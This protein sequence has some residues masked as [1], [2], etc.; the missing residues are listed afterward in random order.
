MKPRGFREFE[1]GTRARYVG[2]KC[3]C[4]D[5]RAANTAYYHEQQAA[6]KAAALAAAGVIVSPS[7][8]VPEQR[9]ARDGTTRT[10]WYSTAACPGPGQGVQCP[11]RAHLR[12]DSVGG[13]CARC[14]QALVWNGLVDAT[15]VRRHLHRLSRQGIGYKTVG[16][17]CDVAKSTLFRLRTGDKTRLRKSTAARILAVDAGARADHA[18]VPA[19][20]TWRLI[21]KLLAEGYTKGAIAQRLGASTPALQIR[22]TKV[23]ARTQLKVER[24][25][26]QQVL[27]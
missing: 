21:Q 16:D 17:A 23:R 12:T 11:A 7:A 27:A 9:T 4:D 18:L 3:R 5:C 1:H 15:P 14:R 24:L 2:H 22:K 25:Y 20:R 10:R 6:A 26:R 8:P 19:T 13:F